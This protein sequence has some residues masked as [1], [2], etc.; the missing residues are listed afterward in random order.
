MAT[1]YKLID[2]AVLTGNQTS[3][4]FSGLGAYSS[5]YTDLYVLASCRTDRSGTADDDVTIKPNNSTSSA[6]A[7]LLLGDGS[8]AASYTGSQIYIAAKA[9]TA[10]ANTFSNCSVYLPNYSSS[11]YKSFS[12]DITG[13][14]NTTA[15]NMQL[16]AQLWSNTAAITSLVFVPRYGTNF[17]SGTSIYL[18]GIK[19]S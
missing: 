3:I 5:D 2:K 9:S 18:Y 6:S 19:N 11:N 8:S 10:T 13:E 16:V 14:D 12:V 4:T 7:I 1:T 17:V 15:T